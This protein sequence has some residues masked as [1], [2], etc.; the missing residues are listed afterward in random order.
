MREK[1]FTVTFFLII[2][3]PF[4]FA[5]QALELLN[6]AQRHKAKNGYF[7]SPTHSTDDNFLIVSGLKLNRQLNKINL[8]TGMKN[9]HK[10]LF[11]R[12]LLFD[13]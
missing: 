10:L 7:L 9:V 1:L 2:T 13:V 5:H 6:T 8:E 11:L 12:R 4:F 3:S